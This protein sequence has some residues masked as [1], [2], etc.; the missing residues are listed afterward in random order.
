[1]VEVA[2]DYIGIDLGT[3][4]SVVGL[5]NSRTSSVEILQNPD[6]NKTSTPSVVAYKADG[7]IAVGVTAV[8]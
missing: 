4:I 5:W 3:C 8:N 7:S 6:D 1:M 2:E